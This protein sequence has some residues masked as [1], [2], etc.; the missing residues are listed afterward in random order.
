MTV[1]LE[2]VS[3]TQLL[4]A[5]RA[6]KVLRMPSLAER[7]DHLAND[8]FVAGTAATLLRGTHSL[9]VHVRLQTTEHRIQL[10]GLVLLILLLAVKAVVPAER[11][12]R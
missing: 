2:E 10:S 7:S 12:E 4:V 6:H 9:S 5:V 3:G 1:A 11:S 8:G